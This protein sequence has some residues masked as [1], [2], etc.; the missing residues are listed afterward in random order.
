MLA[1]IGSAQSLQFN[2]V[3]AAVGRLCTS[4]YPCIASVGNELRTVNGRVAHVVGYE[5]GMVEI[6]EACF[7]IP[8]T[9]ISQLNAIIRTT[10]QGWFWVG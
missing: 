9:R 4:S 5:Y 7:G 10:V 1:K 3:V 8:N 6:V 2:A